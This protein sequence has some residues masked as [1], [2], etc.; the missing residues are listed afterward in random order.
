M[1]C[2]YESCSPK[3]QV[4]AE[5]CQESVRSLLGQYLPLAEDPYLKQGLE[6]KGE[7]VVVEQAGANS[8][9]YQSV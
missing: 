7:P 1:I 9:G 4:V 3:V 8:F 2:N 5:Y 6:A